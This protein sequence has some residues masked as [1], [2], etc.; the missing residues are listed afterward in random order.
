MKVHNLCYV[1]VIIRGDGLGGLLELVNPQRSPFFVLFAPE[2]QEFAGSPTSM[3]VTDYQFVSQT[4]L[5]NF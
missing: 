3:G 5:Y 2:V 4:T 1:W